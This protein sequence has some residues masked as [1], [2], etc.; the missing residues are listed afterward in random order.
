MSIY[1]TANTLAVTLTIAE[2]GASLIRDDWM[3]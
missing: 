1:V 3:K 2:K